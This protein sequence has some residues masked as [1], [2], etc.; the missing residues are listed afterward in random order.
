MDIADAREAVAEVD[1]RD[2]EDR[3]ERLAELSAL[4]PEG[5]VGTSGESADL[6]FSDVKATWIYVAHHSPSSIARARR[7]DSAAA[8]ASNPPADDGRTTNERGSASTGPSRSKGRSPPVLCMSRLLAAGLC[9]PVWSQVR[10]CRDR[11]GGPRPL[12]NL[13]GTFRFR[14]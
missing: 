4:L 14:S 13:E 1:S 10:H 3:A 12:R 5:S 7:R 11:P 8:H 6:L 2:L 9:C